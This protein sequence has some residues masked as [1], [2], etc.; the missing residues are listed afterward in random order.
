MDEQSKHAFAELVADPDGIFVIAEIGINHNGDLDIAKQLIATS[1]ESGCDAVKFQKRTIDVVYSPEVLETP[2]ESPW[3][4]STREQKEGLEFGKVEYDEIDRYCKELGIEWF[5]SAWDLPAQEFLA[6]YDLKFNKIASAMATNLDFVRAVAKE[7]KLTFASTGMMTLED[8][9]AM[10]AILRENNCPFVL[11]HTVSVYPC[12]EDMLNLNAID[13]LR[14][15]YDCLVG[16]SGHESTVMPSIVAATK[17][18]VALERHVTLDR[19]MYGSDQAASLAPRGLRELLDQ[20]RRIPVT[21]GDGVKQYMP[22]EDVVASK[23]RY[24]I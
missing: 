23:L 4:S 16:Y 22:G 1:V 12:A 7:G 24:W 17:G 10:V 13:T 9:D 2:R 5:A 20:I 11:M 19:A 14:E 8:V 6:G 21:L 18:I 3:G 15:R